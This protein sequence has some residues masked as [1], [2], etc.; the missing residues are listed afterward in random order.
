MRCDGLHL[1]EKRAIVYSQHA[2]IAKTKGIVPPL[3]MYVPQ[4]VYQDNAMHTAILVNIT[5]Y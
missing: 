2:N 3:A 1:Q 5:Q 4:E